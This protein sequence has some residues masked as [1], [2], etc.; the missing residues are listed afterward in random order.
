MKTLLRAESRSY[1]QDERLFVELDQRRMRDVQKQIKAA[2]HTDS[3]GQVALGDVL[4]AV[5]SVPRFVD[6]IPMRLND[7]RKRD[8]RQ[9]L[10]EELACL[11]S[12]KNEIE[13]VC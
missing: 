6:A 7:L 1:T 2:I 11:A 12:A 10:K 4:N 13:Q 9:Q 3:N 8:E 5:A